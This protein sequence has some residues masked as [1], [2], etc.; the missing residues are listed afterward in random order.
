M[1]CFNQTNPFDF[2][3]LKRYIYYP[4]NNT[5]PKL[6][7][8]SY[9]KCKF[10]ITGVQKHRK[11]WIFPYL[12]FWNNE[13]SWNLDTYKNEFWTLTFVLASWTVERFAIKRISK[14]IFCRTIFMLNCGLLSTQICYRKGCQGKFC[15]GKELWNN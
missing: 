5:I 6:C 1:C 11:V 4:F 3:K 14:I 10:A 7:G 9:Y 2:K 8:R 12:S 15:Q 13:I